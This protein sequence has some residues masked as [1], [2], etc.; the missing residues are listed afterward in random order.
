MS[1]LRKRRFLLLLLLICGKHFVWA[2]KSAGEYQLKA[3]FLFN[4]TQ[5][6]DWPP[7][8]F[9]SA[10]APMV[11]GIWGKNPFGSYLEEAV[12]GENVNGHPLSVQYCKRAEDL[13]TCHILFINQEEPNKENIIESVK[14]QSTLTVSDDSD[15]LRQGGMIRFFTRN[16]KIHLQINHELTK[17]AKLNVSSK[18]LKLAEIFVP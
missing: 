1:V 9:A 16:N 10:N 17:S 14:G 15:F 11:I 18:L 12:S 8:A 5:F 7:A 2:Q 6:V 4:F 13:K 3:V